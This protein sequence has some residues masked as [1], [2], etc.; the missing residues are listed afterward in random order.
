MSLF[1]TFT[2]YYLEKIHRLFSF[3]V[4][5]EPTAI[6]QGRAIGRIT[7]TEWRCKKYIIIAV[8]KQLSIA[9]LYYETWCNKV[10]E[11]GAKILILRLNLRLN[12][13]GASKRGRS[14]CNLF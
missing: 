13:Y 4:E 12:F 11:F 6:D 8:E 14:A 2:F 1:S 7:G 5:P 9:F 3:E 10:Y